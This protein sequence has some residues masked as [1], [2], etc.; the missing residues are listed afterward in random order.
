MKL[1]ETSLPGV[2]II[3]P[4]VFEDAR[5]FFLESYHQERF[6]ALGL[7]APFVQDNHAR[8]TRGTLRGLHYQLA[9][10]QGKL[11]RVVQGE[12]FDVAVD[13]RGGSPTFGQWTGAVLSDQNKRQIWVPRGFAHGY[14]VLSESADFLYKCDDFY[15]ADD[16]YSVAWD[17]PQIGITWPL[18]GLTQNDLILAEKDRSAPLLK[19]ILPQHLPPFAASL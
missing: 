3:E 16:Q 1:I 7:E 15:R 11:C 5:G 19:D 8:S 9:Q 13:I 17:D 18:N 14:L 2:V 12:V 6:A 10:P 4:R